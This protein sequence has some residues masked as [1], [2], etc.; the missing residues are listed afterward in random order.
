[1]IPSCIGKFSLNTT[2]GR[3][4]LIAPFDYESGFVEFALDVEV[5]DNSGNSDGTTIYIYVSDINDHTP[6]FVDP[7][8]ELTTIV[9]I[10]EVSGPLLD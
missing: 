9:N 7:T 5:R 3:L 2:T 1:M 4:T 6:T 8:G 10:D